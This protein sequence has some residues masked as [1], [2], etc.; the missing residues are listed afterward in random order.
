MTTTLTQAIQ[1]AQAPATSTGVVLPAA[2]AAN[3][4]ELADVRAAMKVLEDRE[5]NLKTVVRDFLEANDVDSAT[6]G[7]VTVFRSEHE[8][9]GVDRK[10][11]EALYPRV[12]ADV[13]TTTPVVQ[14]RAEVK[15]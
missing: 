12:L 2:L 11:L 6:D 3:G 4:R 5:K 7:K 15:D 14:I 1:R 9:T 8:R 10:R 13:A